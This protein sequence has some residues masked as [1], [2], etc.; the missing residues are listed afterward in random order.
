MISGLGEVFGGLQLSQPRSDGDPS[1]L[2]VDGNLTGISLP[3][4]LQLLCAGM[5]RPI[6][7]PFS[8]PYPFARRA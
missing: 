7:R 3:A 4:S 6:G 1:V 5:G 8:I 2:N